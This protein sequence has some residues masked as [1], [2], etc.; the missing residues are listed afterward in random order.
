MS[1]LKSIKALEKLEGRS[2]TEGEKSFI[3]E[4]VIE[5][6][7]IEELSKV[8]HL[9]SPAEKIKEIVH[10][11]DYPSPIECI[12]CNTIY[13][14]SIE[15][16]E[17]EHRKRH[18][19]KILAERIYG[20]IATEKE[21]S[22][23]RSYVSKEKNVYENTMGCMDIDKS[24]EELL[25]YCYWSRSIEGCNF[26]LMHPSLKEYT[27]YYKNGASFMP[28]GKTYI[29]MK[30]YKNLYNSDKYLEYYKELSR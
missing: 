18:E 13:D 29:N 8:L 24:Y 23:I 15:E 10:T 11:N 5:A 17:E 14:P 25:I 22:M 30:E 21:R 12:Y 2:L 28:L 9:H 19:R 4:N 26:D 3:R 27:I 7:S 6:K 1:N 20:H 16:D